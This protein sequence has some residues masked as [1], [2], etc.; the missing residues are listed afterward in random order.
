MSSIEFVLFKSKYFTIST[1]RQLKEQGHDHGASAGY[2][3]NNKV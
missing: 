3:G 1:R 2:Y